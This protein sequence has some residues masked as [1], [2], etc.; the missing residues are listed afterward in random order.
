[1]AFVTPTNVTV[2]SVL[3]A[4][5]YNQEVVENTSVLRSYSNRYAEFRRSS[6]NLT[7]TGTTTYSTLTTVGT[8]ADLTLNASAGDVIQAGAF[9]SLD[10]AAVLLNFD[11]VTVVGGTV[12]NSFTL[13]GAAPAANVNLNTSGFFVPNGVSWAINGSQNYTLV[14]GDIST[15]TVTLRFRYS[16]AAATNRTIFADSTRPM[17]LWSRN[18]GPVT[19]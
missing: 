12:T 14:A 5:K 11:W 9:M 15:G 19:T 7:L 1:M 10:N 6:G 16:M 2:G 13:N 18:H 8:A 4:S 17:Q 3:T